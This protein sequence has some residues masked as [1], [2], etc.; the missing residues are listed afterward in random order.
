MVQHGYCVFTQYNSFTDEIGWLTAHIPEASSGS[1]GGC[2]VVSG[3][4]LYTRDKIEYTALLKTAGWTQETTTWKS[5]EV[6]NTPVYRLYNPATGEHHYTADAHERQ[7]LIN[8]NKWRD[9]GTVF[10]SDDA[11]GV[12]VYRLFNPNGSGVN[13]HHYTTDENE[14]NVL[15]SQYGW[16]DESVGWYGLK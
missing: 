7:V 14:R 6:S 11:K 5:P 13:S 15:I 1:H 4:H 12:K 2:F 3:E 9:E 16:R 10:Y 8:E